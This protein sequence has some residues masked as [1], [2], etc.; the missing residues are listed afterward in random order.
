MIDDARNHYVKLLCS[1]DIIAF[2]KYVALGKEK[3][4]SISFK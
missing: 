2:L 3:E 1:I 4:T